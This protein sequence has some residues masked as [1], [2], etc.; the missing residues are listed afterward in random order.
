MPT[1]ILWARKDRV[2]PD[3]YR[4]QKDLPN[5]QLI[6]VPEAGHFKP[7]MVTQHLLDFLAPV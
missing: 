6:K 2:C 7:E 1:L 5:T 3:A 4:L